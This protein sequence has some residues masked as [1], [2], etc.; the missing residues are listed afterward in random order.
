MANAIGKAPF[1][2]EFWVD[3]FVVKLH[4][5]D[6]TSFLCILLY[7][8]VFYSSFVY[9][10]LYCGECVLLSRTH[11]KGTK[12]FRFIHTHL[13]AWPICTG[14]PLHSHLCVHVERE[15][16]DRSHIEYVNRNAQCVEIRTKHDECWCFEMENPKHMLFKLIL[17]RRNDNPKLNTSIEYMSC[18]HRMPATWNGTQIHKH[19]NK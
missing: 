10:H 8:S 6:I 2:L 12:H 11:M 7:N 5:I 3:E 14:C 4:S 15:M 19:L 1:A 9:Q 18:W 13:V 17:L 16:S